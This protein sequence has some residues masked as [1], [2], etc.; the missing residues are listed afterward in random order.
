MVVEGGGAERVLADVVNG[1]VARGHSLTVVTFDRQGDSYFYDLDSRIERYGLNISSPGKPTSRLSLPKGI[2]RLRQLV[3]CA[4]PD[5]VV[6]FMHSAYIPVV[7]GLSGLGVPVVVSEHID[8]AHYRGRFFQG[9][10]AHAAT[11][12]AAAK[13]V[14]SIVVHA[15]ENRRTIAKTYVMCN[16]VDPNHFTPTDL[17]DCITGTPIL[18]SAGRFMEQK[19]FSTLISAFGQLASDFPN[20]RLRIVGDG[21]QRSKL[22]AQI[23][24]EKLSD[25]VELPGMSRDIRRDYAESTIFVLPSLYESFGLVTAEALASGRPVIGFADCLGT[26]ALVK[27]GI[28]GF[29]ADPAAYPDRTTALVRTLE[30]LMRDPILRARLGAAGPA[31]VKQFAPDAVVDAW[32]NLLVRVAEKPLG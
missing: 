22:E 17:P 32:E 2:W 30:P 7:A 5:A 18:L 25:R 6:A 8:A 21:D 16:P 23:E 24:T 27:S 26:A 9:L 14:P 10:A 19:D 12:F 4:Q 15:E 13:T 11:I 3:R 20:W 1:L 31:S 29:L 28:N